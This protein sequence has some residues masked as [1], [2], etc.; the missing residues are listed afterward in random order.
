MMKKFIAVAALSLALVAGGFIAHSANAASWAFGSTTLSYHTTDSADT[1]TLQTALNAVDNAGLTVDGIFGNGTKAALEAFQSGHS[2]SVDGVAGPLT[3]AALNNAG[4]SMSMTGGSTACPAGFTC[5]STTPS[6][7]VSCPVGFTCVSNTTGTS[8]NNTTGPLSINQIYSGSGYSNTNVGVGATDTQVADLRIVTGAGGSGNLT[9]LNATFTN[10]GTGDFQFTK[11]A[12]AVDVWS[13][14]AKVGS[15]PSTD[16]TEYNSSFS[17]YIPLSG[18]VLNANTT[19][20]LYIAIDAL[21][22]IDSANLGS[23][24]NNFYISGVNLR[25]SDSTGSNYQYSNISNTQSVSS[26]INISN[27]LG[28]TNF[29]FN[30]SASANS[31]KLTV[32]KDPTDSTDRT[33]MASASSQTQSVTLATIDLNAQGTAVNVSRIPVTVEVQGTGSSVTD[34]SQVVNTLRLFNSA[35]VQLDS[36]SIPSGSTAACSS[37]D[38][39]SSFSGI[40]GAKCYVVTFQNFSNSGSNNNS[41]GFTIPAGSTQVYTIKGDINALTGSYF[42][43]GTYVGA[44]ISTNDVAAIQA[45]DQNDNLLPQNSTYLVGSTTAS[46]NYFYVN[47]INVTSNG[48]PSATAG[49]AGGSSHQIST[50]TIPFSVSAFGSTAYVPSTAS[51]ATTAM[52]TGTTVQFGIDDSAGPLRTNA[53]VQSTTVGGTIAYQG[54]TAGNSLTPVGGLYQINAGTTGNFVLTVSLTPTGTD[55]AGQFRTDL[56]NVNWSNDNS[57]S[58]YTGVP[59]TGFDA[60]YAGLNAQQFQTPYISLQ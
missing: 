23:G 4:S 17:G 25:Y 59:S 29:V 6:T 58:S 47:S 57:A 30:T 19:S 9:G 5:T 53:D 8:V 45:Y 16:F 26:P 31:I 7:T 24:Y 21:P 33:Q 56:L 51:F 41:Y 3:F 10:E 13:N 54:G 46:K 1:M 18:A 38:S 43:P 42:T 52:P 49:S 14:G 11:Y 28:N 35:G 27:A 22:V 15:L 37:A 20:D 44:E 2:L 12:S 39:S 48:T 60:Y 34:V 36:E 55:G 32:T 50:M 40:S